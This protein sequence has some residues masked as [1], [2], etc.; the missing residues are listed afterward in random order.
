MCLTFEDLNLE[1]FGQER[2]VALALSGGPDSMALAWLLSCWSAEVNG[3]EIHAL[4]VDHGLRRESAEEAQ[5]VKDRVKDWPKITPHILCWKGKKPENRIMEEAR[6]A[7]YR[8]METY[9]W[10]KN[11]SCL[12]I[13]HH[14][15]DQAETFLIRLAAGSGLDGLSGMKDVQPYKDD[16][17]LVRPLLNAGKEDLIEVCRKNDI[18]YVEDPS[19]LSPDYLRPRLRG[20]REVLEAEGLTSKR[21]ARTA[22]RLGRARRAL[23]EIA[24]RAFEESLKDKNEHRLVFDL[25]ALRRQP[26]EISL[27]VVSK[28]IAYLGCGQEYGPRMEK[29]EA[30]FDKIME[31][32]NF[33]PCTLGGVRFAIRDKNTSLWMERE[34]Q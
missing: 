28:A 2:C 33:K 31:D 27:R 12:F 3:P 25:P 11:I 14:R 8:L 21:L 9:C 29:L 15:D 20:A 22:Q 4:T 16:L 26:E 13:A 1:R 5:Q 34:H 7:R 18:S 32:K 19:N 17:T 23:E 10:E 6:R 30:L 24:E